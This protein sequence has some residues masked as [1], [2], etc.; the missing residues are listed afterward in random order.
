MFLGFMVS[1]QAEPNRLASFPEFSELPAQSSLPDPLKCLDGHV[2]RTAKE[3][4]AT[5]R[6]E[7]KALLAHYEYGEI[8][9]KPT[10]MEFVVRGQYTNVLEGKGILKLVTIKTGGNGSPQIDLALV[11]PNSSAKPVPIILVMNFCGNQA[12]MNDSRIPL[13]RS[14]VGKSCPG[15]GDNV[16]TEKSRG[17]QSTN[18]PLAEMIAR[19][20]GVATFYSGDV[21]PDRSEV[22]EGLYQWLAEKKGTPNNS[23]NRGTIAAWAWGFSRCVDYLEKD[24]SINTNKIA[25][26]GHSRNGKTALL[27]GAFDARIS[28]V[29][30]HQAGTGGSAPSR[31]KTGESVKAINDHFPH[32]FNAIFKTFNDEPE[33]LPIDQNS[34]LALCAPRPVLFS[35]ATEDSWGNPGGQFEVMKATDQ[36]YRFL[37]VEGLESVQMPAP[38]KLMASRL[39]FY[40]RSGKHSM[41]AADWEIFLDFADKQW[42][43]L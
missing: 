40:L 38:G 8:P 5:R 19:G 32:W 14:W 1:A 42:G 26:L 16:A 24:S 27:A 20:Y 3:F 37:G 9:S 2:A 41:T 23:T 39:G 30:V 25:A 35:A 34:L 28:L 33:R 31:G 15:C 13:T 29:L 7:L 10:G 4:F 43:K 22:S 12:V 36:V 11:L 17:T 21:D 18:W 6:P